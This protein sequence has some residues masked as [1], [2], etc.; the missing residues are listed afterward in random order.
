MSIFYRT[1][2][3]AVVGEEGDEDDDNRDFTSLG[4]TATYEGDLS[5]LSGCNFREIKCRLIFF[6]YATIAVCGGELETESG[7]LASPN[8]PED[9]HPNKECVWKISVPEGYQVAL[10]FQSFEIENHDSCVYDYLEVRDGPDSASPLVGTFCGYKMPEDVRSN[11]S[12]LY[13]KFVSDGS[14]QKAGFAA[15]FMKEYDECATSAH[16]H[17]SADMHG[18]EHECINTLGGYKCRCQIGYELHSD[19]KRCESESDRSN[20]CA[21]HACVA[22]RPITSWLILGLVGVL[23]GKGTDQA[24]LTLHVTGRVALF[25][26]PFRR[27]RRPD[28][29]CQRHHH[30]PVLPGPVPGQQELRLGDTGAA[31]VEDH[32]QLHAL[33]HRGEQCELQIFYS[34]LQFPVL[35][36]RLCF[37]K[38]ANTTASPSP[39]RWG[40]G[41]FA[42]TDSTA[43]RG[44]K[45][46]F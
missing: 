11:G 12:A 2:V 45:C 19:E 4:F 30:L 26:C 15:S 6:L 9:Y 44:K 34:I 16:A 18:C 39:P 43:V 27:L 22:F 23:I 42:S 41:R 32:G 10:K 31:A 8:Y 5:D 14:V 21:F 25:F 37:S 24:W 28:R 46:S 36:P 7:Q 29:R 38:T 20:C 13:V 1:S 33:R 40:R 3:P 17:T 35:I